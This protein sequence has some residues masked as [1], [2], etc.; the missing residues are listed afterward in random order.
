MA[1]C[2]DIRY[3]EIVLVRN[4]LVNTRDEAVRDPASILFPIF[5][6]LLST[7]FLVTMQAVDKQRSDE[8][9]V[10]PWD[11]VASATGGTGGEAKHQVARVVGV[12]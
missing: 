8:D 7:A 11:Q 4:S 5:P 3:L 12:S 1:D 2:L 10:G 9:H 6:I